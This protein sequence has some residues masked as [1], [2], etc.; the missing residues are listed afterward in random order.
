[1]YTQ[2]CTGEKYTKTF[3]VYIQEN[4]KIISPFHDISTYSGTEEDIINVFNEIPRFENG[5]FEM[6]K[7]EKLNPIMQ[8][9]K[10]EQVRFVANVFPLKG[11]PW[12]YGAIPQTWEN[13]EV[14]DELTGETG[15]NDPI[16]VIEIGKKRKKIGEVYKAKI[17]GGLALIDD[18]E[19][20]WKIVVVDVEDE[21]ANLLNDIG[22]VDKVYPGML[23]STFE[24]FRDY[25]IPGGSPPNRFG[26]NGE[27]LCKEHAIKVVKNAQEHWKCLME[28]DVGKDISKHNTTLKNSKHFMNEE[29]VVAGSPIP[30]DSVPELVHEYFF[31][32]K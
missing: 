24:W 1:M 8:D 28:A 22:D 26:L 27:F 23:R 4:G 20:D 16:D 25:K 31:I 6:N 11:Y 10:K 29:F 14:K 19:C 2:I 3:K 18:G 21:N 17:L 9:I 15:D 32:K 5:K 13:P 7:K 30:K 12:N